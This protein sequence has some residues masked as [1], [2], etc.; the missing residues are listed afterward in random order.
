MTRL[1]ILIFLVH[2]VFDSA[3]QASYED[4]KSALIIQFSRNVSWPDESE[5][6][7]FRIGIYGSDITYRRLRDQRLSVKGKAVEFLRLTNIRN[8][9]EIEVLFIG[10]NA[11]N[12]V[13]ESYQL[14][15]GREILLI[16]EQYEDAKYIMLNITSPDE[17]NQVSFEIN[18][19]NIILENLS[20][21]P[22]L[23][24]LGGTE[25][26]VRELY[27]EMR[28]TLENQ[29]S[30][31]EKQ[32]EQIARSQLEIRELRQRISEARRENEALVSN[33]MSLRNEIDQSEQ[34]L[35]HFQD[36]ISVQQELIMAQEKELSTREERLAQQSI[37]L[38]RQGLMINIRSKNLDSLITES[39]K[40][41]AIINE[42]V[43]ILDT[44]EELIS[45]QERLIIIF[46]GILVIIVSLI[47]VAIRA[48]R[49]KTKVSQQLE[50]TNKE[51]NNSNETLKSQ[52]SEL[53][54]ALTELEL[55]QLQLLQSEKMAALGILTAGV[56][57]EINNPVNF[58]KSGTEILKSLE[59]SVS[60]GSEEDRV[61]NRKVLENINI[62][63]ERIITI[64]KSL[65]SFSRSDETKI[66]PCNLH[67]I[68]EDCLTIL[69]HEYKDHVEII[70]DYDQGELYTEGNRGKLYQVFTNLLSNSIQAIKGLGKIFVVT[71]LK[72]GIIEIRISDTGEGIPQE[73]LKKIYDPFF[74][75]KEP[76]KGTGLGLSI[77]YTIMKEHN[78]SIH[79]DS[80]LGV[81]TEV[82]LKFTANNKI[83]ENVQHP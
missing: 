76:G 33:T 12:E 16:S 23:L 79:F 46:A 72:K 60:F 45:F 59:K 28:L 37:A 71:S 1:V 27:Q 81:G 62:G 64:V 26:D 48:Y 61:L 41:Q 11:A 55:A 51:L 15:T 32:Q 19:A 78:A 40:Q 36:S 63:I 58:I 10:K 43:T 2:F 50:V 47:F 9:P 74:T 14:I 29:T 69:A 25:V 65:N 30:E 77:V 75:T 44:K 13:R 67:T 21:N 54:T 49:I 34:Q 4:L 39:N 6:K 42:Q 52:K 80:E 73:D 83:L 82:L 68:I 5:I 70:R 57:H 20:I 31:V 24:L 18:K 8:L 53:Q 3:G 66:E 22:K 17:N 35:R 56:A 7:S 38:D